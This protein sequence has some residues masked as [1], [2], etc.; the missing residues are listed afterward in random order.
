MRRD[1][2]VAGLG[3]LGMIALFLFGVMV[4]TVVGFNVAVKEISGCEEVDCSSIGI[5]SDI[6]ESCEMCSSNVRIIKGG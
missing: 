2:V 6:V 3:V 5:D 1:K 4:G